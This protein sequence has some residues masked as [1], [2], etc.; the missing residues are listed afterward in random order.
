MPKAE[1]GLPV[2]A[3]SAADALVNTARLAGSLIT[4]KLRAHRNVAGL[5]MEAGAIMVDHDL[6]AIGDKLNGWR[7]GPFV[8]IQA[9]HASLVADRAP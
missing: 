6:E 8:L 2:V 3:C 7:L 5:A 9:G 4:Q 1:R